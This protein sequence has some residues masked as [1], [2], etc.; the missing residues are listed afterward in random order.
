MRLVTYDYIFYG[1]EKEERICY[2]RLKELEERNLCRFCVDEPFRE[3]GSLQRFFFE[4]FY[5]AQQWRN[6][7]FVSSFIRLFAGPIWMH[8]SCY[9]FWIFFSFIVAKKKRA[10]W[11]RKETKNQTRTENH[12]RRRL[13]GERKYERKKISLY[14][15]SLSDLC[16]FRFWLFWHRKKRAYKYFSTLRM[17]G[18]FIAFLRFVFI[19]V[20]FVYVYLLARVPAFAQKFASLLL[21]TSRWDLESLLSQLFFSLSREWKWRRR[22]NFS[23]KCFFNHGMK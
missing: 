13:G 12:L 2:S 3:S 14:E 4:I 8:S 19:G 18:F 9:T 17:C 23:C 21:C 20:W 6:H 7:D 10:R 1:F 15:C 16:W 22:S 11:R 5:G